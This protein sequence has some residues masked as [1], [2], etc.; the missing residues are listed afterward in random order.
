MKERV[1]L[2]REVDKL[3]L[4]VRKTSAEI[5]WYENAAK[6]MDIIIDNV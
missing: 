4:Q 3:Q 5:G 6:E 2:A 1:K